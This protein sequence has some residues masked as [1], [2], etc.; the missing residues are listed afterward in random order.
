MPHF[1][2]D[3]SAN[4]H[5]RLDFQT[6]FKELHT[7]VVSTGAFPIGG[8]R[9]RAIRCDDYYVADGREE[10]AYINLTLKIGAGRPFELREEVAKKVFEIF[11]D[12]MKPITD[13]T[14]VMISFEMSELEPV[15]KF[16]KNNIHPLFKD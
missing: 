15:L 2:V 3:Y 7:Y 8:A 10:F 14:Y 9:S 6:L 1:V 13:N 16:N 11:T 5:D 12:W 4:L